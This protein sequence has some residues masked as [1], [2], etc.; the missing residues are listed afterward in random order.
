MTMKKILSVFILSMSIL[1]TFAQ[2][3]EMF[4]YQGVARTSTGEPIADQ[5]IGL[6]ISILSGGVSGTAV[7]VETHSLTTNTI[8]LYNTQ[9]GNGT[10]MSG[11]FTTIDWGA[12]TY[13]VKVEI[14]ENG[15][16][17]YVLAG[18]S[19]LLS[20]P[21]ALYAKTAENV[22][23]GDADNTNE[24]QVLTLNGAELSL[25]NGGGSVTLT[26][27]VDTD[28]QTLSLSGNI[29]SISEG[30][31]V[32][33]S[34]VGHQDLILSG[35]TLS[36]TDGNSIDLSSIQGDTDTDDQTLSIS[37]NSI[38]ISEGN[39]VDISGIDTDDQTLV[40]SGTTL[41]ITDG[42]SVD[43]SSLQSGGGGHYVGEEFG[44]GVVF[45]TYS[46]AT[47]EHGLIVNTEEFLAPW[48]LDGTDVN[49]CES[50]WNGA[51]N[52][53]SIMS[54]GALSTDAAGICV[55]L[56]TGGNSDWY[57]PAID[58]LILL[59][60]NRFT[61]NMALEGISGADLLQYL[62]ANQYCSS[63]EVSAG[64]CMGFKCQLFET[65]LGTGKNYST[66][67]RAIRKF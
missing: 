50:S 48:G 5:N 10:L 6:Q 37:G 26:G 62:S 47:G 65:S 31:G 15:G 28:D 42:N 52:T 21:Y 64:G 13:F 12:S 44:G 53:T 3:P 58:E 46:D 60:E 14:D 35:T 27:G 32:D 23:D 61:V 30:N 43:L 57:L 63:T 25:S 2:A 9:I 39:S 67:I 55:N 49:S 16:S 45:Y 54:A 41:S 1:L 18:T 33:I 11:D 24:L 56:S 34:S 7:Y 51:A 8:G 36:I 22:D 4:N 66:Y 19:Q 29:L 38:S 20:V 59:F 17:S 40:F